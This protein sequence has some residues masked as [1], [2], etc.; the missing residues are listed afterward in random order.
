MVTTAIQLQQ[1]QTITDTIIVEEALSWI[2]T[3]YEF[4]QL[5]K[6]VGC[7]CCTYLI[8][9]FVGLGLI[10]QEDVDREL[11]ALGVYSGDWF[12]HTTNEHYLRILMKFA[13]NIMETRCYPSTIAQPGSIVLTKAYGLSKRW[14]HGGIVTKWPKLIHAV[15]PYV[16][17]TDASRDPMWMFQ[18]IGIYRIQ[19]T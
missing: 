15:S 14:N 9:V 17:E 16:C 2:K 7:D 1:T 19:G 4:G 8:G 12:R 5:L 18:E 10:K 6:G 3:P 13:T 11:Q